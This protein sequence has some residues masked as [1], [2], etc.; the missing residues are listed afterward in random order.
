MTPPNDTTVDNAPLD[1]PDWEED[2]F[3]NSAEFAG[4]PVSG[5]D[6]FSYGGSSSWN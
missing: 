5:S 1:G 4:N 3:D 6:I 2:L